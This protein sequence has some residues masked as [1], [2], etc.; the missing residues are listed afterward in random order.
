MRAL[1]AAER[2]ERVPHS[3]LERHFLRVLRGSGLPAPERQLEIRAPN[4]KLVARVDFCWS[5]FRRIVEVG[6]HGR[7]ATRRE[8]SH[9]ARRAAQLE[10][11]GWRVTVFTYEQVRDDPAFVLGV[12][13]GLLT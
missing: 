7:H 10:L 5:P 8:R 1:I 2:G 4:G 9:D 6:G 13:R 3:V 12:L 11:L